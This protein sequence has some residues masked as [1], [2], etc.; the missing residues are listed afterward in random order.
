MIACF[1]PC[2]LKQEDE[3]LSFFL[4]D[5]LILSFIY[6][7][8]ISFLLFFLNV[9]MQ[10]L[11][12]CYSFISLCFILVFMYIGEVSCTPLSYVY[13]FSLKSFPLEVSELII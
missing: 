3:S 6:S 8:F 4:Y 10:T 2:N 1:S 13:T 11:L 9:H 5:N 12:N 7:L